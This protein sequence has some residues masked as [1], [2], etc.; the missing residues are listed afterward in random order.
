MPPQGHNFITKTGEFIEKTVYFL[1]VIILFILF[2]I[3][4]NIKE[5]MKNN[6]HP[7]MK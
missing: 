2:I 7:I 6:T 3:I 5:E 4:E 1:Q